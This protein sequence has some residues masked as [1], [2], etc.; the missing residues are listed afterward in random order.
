MNEAMLDQ[1][2]VRLVRCG[3]G[4][5]ADPDHEAPQASKLTKPAPV[6]S[7]STAGWATSTHTNA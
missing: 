5:H 3:G 2:V 4:A 7:I 1:L 6:A